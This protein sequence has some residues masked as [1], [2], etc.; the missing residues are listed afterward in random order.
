MRVMMFSMLDKNKIEELKDK[1]NKE[2]A[3]LLGELK[4]LGR[5]NPENS[6]DWEATPGDSDIS[7][8]DSSEVADKI[9][10]FEERSST[11]EELEER[12]KEVELAIKNIS[13]NNYGKCTVCD[14][15]IEIERLEV[16][17]AA[18]TCL[19]HIEK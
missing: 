5:I 9:E 2:K 16:N 15:E 18:K 6:E 14:K 10:E 12:L 1:L 13:E 11:E 3:V 19:S 8:A 17:P 4:G 7:E